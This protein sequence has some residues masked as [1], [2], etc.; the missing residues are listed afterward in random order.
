MKGHTETSFGSI[1]RAKKYLKRKL[2][3]DFSDDVKGHTN[4]SFGSIPRAKKYSKSKWS[5]DSS[6]SVKAQ[7]ETSFG[8][9]PRAKKYSKRKFEEINPRDNIMHYTA[10][11]NEN[12]KVIGYTVET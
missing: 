11:E 7:T 8:S 6:D 9:I 4:T 12:L 3:D 10:M 1:P 5:D 2:S